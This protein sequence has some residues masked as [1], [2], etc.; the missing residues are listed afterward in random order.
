MDSIREHNRVLA[1]RVIKGLESRNMKGFYAE[2]REEAL[3]LALELVG[4]AGSITAGS[5]L[6]AEQI[7]LL[8]ALENGGYPYIDRNHETDPARKAE[9]E[10]QAFSCDV[11]I[12]GAN[13]ISADGEI[14]NI[15]GHAN[16]VACIAFGPAS[17]LIIAGMNKV[18]PTLE[19]AMT[20]ARNVAAPINAARYHLESPC[21]KKGS[22]YDCKIP[23][24][25]C[26]QIL[27]TRYS[28]IRDRIKVI[29]VGEELGY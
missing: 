17:V 6:S 27:I 9:M 24:G 20:R 29:L 10:R 8:G 15:D 3:K 11:Y 22:C 5:S 14:V 16:R 26:C 1:A 23:G 21:G 19:D 4:D 25:I 13:A 2:T 7:G 12:G 28:Q 18:A